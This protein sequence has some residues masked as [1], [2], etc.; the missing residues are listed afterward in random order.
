MWLFLIIG[1]DEK[2]AN[3]VVNCHLPS[4]V[5]RYC[6]NGSRPGLCVFGREYSQLKKYSVFTKRAVVF[7]AIRTNKMTSTALNVRREF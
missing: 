6:G 3:K 7:R 4:N 1:T 2:T 5:H